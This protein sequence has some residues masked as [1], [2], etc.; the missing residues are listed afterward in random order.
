METFLFA[1][2]DDIAYT[3]LEGAPLYVSTQYKVKK[4]LAS[5]L[6]RRELPT[7]PKS[8]DRDREP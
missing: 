7:A 4:C 8:S 5:V 1:D 3:I 6:P 2:T